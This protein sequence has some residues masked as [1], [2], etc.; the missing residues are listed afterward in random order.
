MLAHS[1]TL[2]LTVLPVIP[3]LVTD[4]FGVGWN[5][6]ALPRA[7]AEP[8]PLDMGSA[9]HIEVGLILIGHIASVYLAHLIAQRSFPDRRQVWLSELPLLALM[10]AYTFVGLSVLSLPLILH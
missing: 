2:L 10:V 5:W 3:F 6:L 4:P 9:W 8:A 1:W 7:S